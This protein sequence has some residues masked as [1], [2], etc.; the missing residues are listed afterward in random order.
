MGTRNEG[1]LW[2]RSLSFSRFLRYTH[3]ARRATLP[4]RYPY[5]VGL[6]HKLCRVIRGTNLSQLCICD[7]RLAYSAWSNLGGGSRST[8]SRI[9][10]SHHSRSTILQTNKTCT[11]HCQ[12][13]SG[14]SITSQLIPSARRCRSR[15]L[16]EHILFVI[17]PRRIHSQDYNRF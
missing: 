8:E 4:S 9:R 10:W 13:H 12:K 14:H 5:R 3:R 11:F 1:M 7:S 15:V 16:D 6:Y 17:A 2:S